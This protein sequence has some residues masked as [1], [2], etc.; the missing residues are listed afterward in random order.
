[1]IRLRTEIEPVRHREPISHDDHI[2][3]LGS[4]FTDNIGALLERDGFRVS[5]NPM[6]ALYNPHSIADAVERALSGR[7][8]TREDL[9]LY[10]GIYHCLS[11]ESRRQ[12][13]DADALLEDLNR[14]FSAF[15]AELRAADIWIITF[16]TAYV[17]EYTADGHIV[18]NCHK[19]P[20]QSFVRRRL[21]VA[22][23]T[24]RWQQ[25]TCGRRVIFTVSP[26]RH[27]ADGLHGN[28]LSKAT[29]LLAAENL[30]EYFPAYEI[31]NDDLRDYRFYDSDLRHPSPTAVEYIYEKF[32]DTYFSKDTCRIAEENRR[33]A[34][35][36]NH[37]QIL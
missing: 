8:F 37:R 23:I 18:G 17:F 12:N 9:V 16:G 7:P 28:Q 14:D 13:A 5:V 6:G 26:V 22:E 3:M 15:A 21:S 1:M 10:E 11:F 4:C 34:A 36:K 20:A 27:L 30:G 35:A 24:G 33:I 29:L 32:K 25:L 19:L 31:L 2:V